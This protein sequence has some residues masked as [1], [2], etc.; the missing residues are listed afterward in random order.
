MRYW[1]LQLAENTAVCKHVGKRSKQLG[2][3]NT[4]VSFPTAK[5]AI[6]HYF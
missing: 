3:N 1:K 2:H 5:I 6:V 4:N